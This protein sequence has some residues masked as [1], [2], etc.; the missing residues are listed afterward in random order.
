MKIT[1]LTKKS[2]VERVAD[3]QA[4]PD[5]WDFKSNKPCLINFHAP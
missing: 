4:Y 5:Q 1:D 3:Y 2:F